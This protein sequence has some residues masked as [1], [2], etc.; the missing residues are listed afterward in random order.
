[1]VPLE[2][3]KHRRYKISEL[4]GEYQEIRPTSLLT[5]DLHDL[6]QPQH[7]VAAGL[8]NFPRKITHSNPQD[9]IQEMEF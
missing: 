4:V 2:G 7:P 3:F 8:R 6:Q 9:S 1:M 5:P